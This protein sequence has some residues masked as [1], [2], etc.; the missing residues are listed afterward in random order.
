MICILAGRAAEELLVGEIS[1]G[2]ANDLQQVNMLAR[3]AVTEFGF[4]ERLG[5]LID[6]AHGQ[7]LRLGDETRRIVDQEVER[8]VADAYRDALALLAAHRPALDRLAEALLDRGQL[9]RLDIALVVG[10]LPP[11]P[12]RQRRLR[13]VPVEVAR[14]R[15]VEELV[16]T[17]PEPGR[18][19]AFARWLESRPRIRRR[20]RVESI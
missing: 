3:R 4:S 12:A 19:V 9:E 2:A 14:S 11:A 15:S 18:A 20:R 1:S 8:L 6:R 5:Q 17:A 16:Q 7:E 13:P 10:E